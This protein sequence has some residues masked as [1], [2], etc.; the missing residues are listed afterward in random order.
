MAAARTV[1]PAKLNDAGA[2]IPRFYLAMAASGAGRAA[3]HLVAAADDTASAASDRVPGDP[4]A[5]GTDP[6]RENASENAAVAHPAARDARCARHRGSSA[7]AAQPTRAPRFLGPDHL[8][9]RRRMG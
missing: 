1:D 3:D 2:R 9:C 8:C 6:A 7:P 5:A 4:P